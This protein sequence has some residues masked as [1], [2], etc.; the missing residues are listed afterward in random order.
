MVLA[1]DTE[2]KRESIHEALRGGQYHTVVG[3]F[4]DHAMAER[5]INAL[6]EA[7]FPEHDV[8]LVAKG[9]EAS[10][11][12]PSQAEAEHATRGAE[13]GIAIGGISGGILG[14]LIGIGAL[15]IPG[16]GPAVAAGWLAAVLGGAATGAALGGWIGSM[17]ELNV[18]EDVAHRY[19]QQVSHG[20]YLVMVLAEQGERQETAE[21]ILSETGSTDVAN[22]P[23]QPR[24][25]QFPGSEKVAPG[26]E[27][28]PMTA[29]E[30]A[31]RIQVG[32]DVVGSDG[33]HVG[34]VKAVEGSDFLVDRQ[35]KSDIYVPINAIREVVARNQEVV[36]SIPAYEVARHEHRTRPGMP[37]GEKDW[38]V[39]PLD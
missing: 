14:G 31:A 10:D 32:M 4:P 27:E 34:R 18:P 36:L 29:E 2:W 17:A 7:G 15:A 9:T 37:P 16:I 1:G 13:K 30:A 6:Y 25:E 26:S 28:P 33:D 19:A 20:N 24:T 8:S 12:I 35:F 5:A 38:E 3:V 21:R 11:E 39:P 23:Y 22:Y